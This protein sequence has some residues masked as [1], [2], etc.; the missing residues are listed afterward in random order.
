MV[1]SIRAKHTSFLV[2]VVVLRV[3]CTTPFDGAFNPRKTN[4]EKKQA[5]YDEK[6]GGTDG[7]DE[8]A[9]LTALKET[10]AARAKELEEAEVT[11]YNDTRTARAPRIRLGT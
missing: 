7:E 3:A 11:L 10:Y 2:F 8:K 4:H 5:T 9:V 6:T 1:N